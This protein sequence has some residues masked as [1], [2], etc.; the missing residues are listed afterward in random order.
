MAVYPDFIKSTGYGDGAGL[1]GWNCRCPAHVLPFVEG[2]SER[3][4][5]DEELAN[6]DPPPF[7]FEGKQYTQYEATQKQREIERTIRK[8]TREKTAYESAG[9]TVDAQNTA[10]RLSILK[11]KYKK[12]SKAAHLPLQND[13]MK[14]IY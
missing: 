8:L 11:S 2:V 3:T 9:L 10:A 4:Y 5:T 12:F 1:G 14:V 13:R 7:T 6:I